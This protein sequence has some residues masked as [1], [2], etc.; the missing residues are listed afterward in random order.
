MYDI[1]GLDAIDLLFEDGSKY[2]QTWYFS[3][4]FT[5]MKKKLTT[6]YINFI[7]AGFIAVVNYIVQQTF[8]GKLE[9]VFEN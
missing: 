7:L 4:F 9:I 6:E 8:E 2:C 1:Y 3:Y 5:D